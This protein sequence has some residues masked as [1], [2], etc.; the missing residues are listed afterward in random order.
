MCLEQLNLACGMLAEMARSNL[1]LSVRFHGS[2]EK[3]TSVVPPMAS[4]RKGVQGGPPGAWLA[5]VCLAPFQG[6]RALSP[7]RSLDGA[8]GRELNA[9]SSSSLVLPEAMW[10][11]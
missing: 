3:A 7:S 10:T 11:P 4:N 6:L 9:Y 8:G 1:G 2:P 5:T